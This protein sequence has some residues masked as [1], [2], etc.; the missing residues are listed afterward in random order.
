MEMGGFSHINS[1]VAAVI[2][3]QPDAELC[4][5]TINTEQPPWNWSGFPSGWSDQV[6]G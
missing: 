2:Q 3:M 4:F 1:C 5:S 6:M